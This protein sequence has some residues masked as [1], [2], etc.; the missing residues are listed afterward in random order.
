MF[1]LFQDLR[2][3][4]RL[5]TRRPGLAFAAVV[6]LAL[7]IGANATVYTWMQGA[8]FRPLARVP[9]QDE[10]VFVQNRPRSGSAW[11]MSYPD[12]V[13]YRDRNKTLAGLIV[14]SDLAVSLTE[15]GRAERVYGAIV[16]GN[17]FDALRVE[18][19]LGRGFLPEEDR[20]PGSHPVV[21]LSHGFWQ[22]RFSG[23][24]SVVGRTISLNT[25]P[26]TVVGI[27]PPGFTGVLVGLRA[28][29]FVPIMMQAEMMGSS[30]LERRGN[31][32]LNAFGR[33]RPGVSLEQARADLNV[34]AAQMAK[35]HPDSNDGMKVDVYNLWN[36]PSG[37][38]RVLGP[39]LW[40]LMAVVL[41]VLLIACANVANLLLGRAL[42]RRREVAI[43]LSMGATRWRLARQLLTESLL[44]ALLGGLG[45]V[46]VARWSAGLLMSF[47]PPT[48]MPL[49]LAVQ[50]DARVLAFTFLI[51]LVAG[52][53]FGLAPA[54]QGS[55]Q[56]IVGTLREESG[57]VAGGRRKAVL[58]NAIVVAQVAL[59]VVLLIGAGLFVRALGA[60]H[61]VRPG[62]NV[63]RV[64]LASLDLFPNGYTRETGLDFHRRLLARVR[65]LPGVESA[66][67]AR[68]AP[69]EL[70]SSSMGI[71]VDGYTPAPD[72]EMSIEY[73]NVA[74][75]YFRTMEIP[76]VRGREFVESDSGEQWTAAVVNEAMAARFWP[77]EEAVG[78]Q[79]HI[80]NRTLSVVGVAKN[81][82]YHS[83]NEAPYAV[84]YLCMWQAYRPDAVLHVRTSG[85]PSAV[86]P[87]LRSEIA[88]LDPNL[89][90][91]D[92]QTMSERMQFAFFVQEIASTLLSV[93]GGLA[94]V[95]AVVGLYGVVAY[96]VGQ[97][98]HEMGIRM[99]LGAAPR[100]ILVLVV[101]QG[102]FVTGLGMGAG[103]LGAAAATRLAA[104][105]LHG[106]SPTDPMTFAAV[107]AL[108]LAVASIAS[109][110]PARRASSLD[111][112]ST[113]HRT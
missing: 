18:P 57:S 102:V 6:S 90:L 86:L 60:A 83:L 75:D 95:L 4:A 37:A 19:V 113:L 65:A 30:Q 94:L 9:D 108:M 26:F 84:M 58:R 63:D 23:D 69:F 5:L 51:S 81:V 45:G 40:V 103:I 110:L 67:I 64:A 49:S 70:G 28:D 2:Y 106:V 79:F 112:I 56:E 36:A 104:S 61:R 98:C 48:D 91:F 15:G 29:L 32:W 24:P 3:G 42:D 43:R 25:R 73:Q 35:E 97:R 71:R 76:I 62:F 1:S 99:A 109:Y 20:T 52:V 27:A 22:R 66:S 46:V 68:R 100:D 12:Y 59:S 11:S 54:F 111:P 44:L 107:I 78:K 55:K 93:F 72:E 77:G 82:K 53:L 105:Q 47:L 50:V 38:A 17:F 85:D 10:I 96:A 7:G 74:P 88:S 21:V 80:G 101:R 16:S 8:L 34:V 89:P 87:V 31:H 13:D 33:L 14:S 41:T 39:V 92:V